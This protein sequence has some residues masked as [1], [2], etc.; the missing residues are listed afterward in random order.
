M[1]VH[2]EGIFLANLPAKRFL[3]RDNSSLLCSK[4]HMIM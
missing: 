4:T 2:V 3:E 1:I